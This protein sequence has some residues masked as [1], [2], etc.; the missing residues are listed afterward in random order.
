MSLLRGKRSD[1]LRQAALEEGALALVR[2]Q[3]ER[4]AVRVG[5][6][7]ALAEPAQEVGARGVEEVVALERQPVEQ[8]EAGARAVRHRDGD[9]AVQLDDRR[10]VRTREL[11]VE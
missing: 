9:R 6:V 1:D 10:R 7:V 4:A 3:L 2:R 11:A 8:R 5:G